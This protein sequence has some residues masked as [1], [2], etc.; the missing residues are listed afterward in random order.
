[1]NTLYME[2]FKNCKLQ[3]FEQNSLSIMHAKNY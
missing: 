3:L 1:M 2:H